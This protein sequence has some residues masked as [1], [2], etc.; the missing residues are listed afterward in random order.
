VTVVPAGATIGVTD[1]LILTAYREDD[2]AAQNSVLI[3]VEVV[4]APL[5][6]P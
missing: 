4:R 2:E 3:A 6:L 1:S 5:V